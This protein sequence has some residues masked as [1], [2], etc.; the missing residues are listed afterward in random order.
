MPDI[1]F[2]H[3]ALAVASVPASV[4]FYERYTDLRVVHRRTDGSARIVWLSDGRRPFVLVLAE[5]QP[6]E[7]PIGPFGHLGIGCPDR[8]E[9]DRLAALAD[10]ADCLV[11]SPEESGYPVGYWALLRDPDGNT[12]ELSYGQEVAATVS[13]RPDPNL[14]RSVTPEP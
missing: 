11:K 1:G 13:A 9:V 5:G 3:V 6:T 4:A 14:T 7:T 8:G 12:V 2:T 10:E